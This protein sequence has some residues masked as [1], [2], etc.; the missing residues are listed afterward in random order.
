LGKKR[1]LRGVVRTCLADSPRSAET[2]PGQSGAAGSLA[3][4]LDKAAENPRFITL[5]DYIDMTTELSA[6]KYAFQADMA[7]N[8]Y[9]L[10]DN[11]Q[12]VLENHPAL[13]DYLLAYAYHVMDVQE[14]SGLKNFILNNR[15]GAKNVVNYAVVGALSLY[16]NFINLFLMLLRLLGGRRD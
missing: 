5:S 8:W 9:G 13:G 15:A 12:A 6:L 11:T 1:E 16:L 4:A 2:S 7:S 10:D 3:A 14:I